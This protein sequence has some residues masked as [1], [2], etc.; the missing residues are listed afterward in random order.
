MPT[1]SESTEDQTFT[2]THLL[3]AQVQELI[4]L[5]TTV[6]ERAERPLL[7]EV[8]G[9]LGVG[10]GGIGLIRHQ[11]AAHQHTALMGVL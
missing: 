6:R 3:V 4:K 9:D 10:D 5:N 2:D 7:L 8:G 11:Q 1:L